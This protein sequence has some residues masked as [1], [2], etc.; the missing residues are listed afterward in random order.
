[1][2]GRKRPAVAL[3]TSA[4]SLTTDSSG[5]LAGPS[6]KRTVTRTVE[7]WIT[8]NDKAIN[9][10]TW[11]KYETADREHVA[12]LKCFVCSRFDDKLHSCR[13]YSASF[14]VGSTNLRTSSFKDHAASDMHRRAMSLLKKSQGAAVVEYAPIAKVLTTLDEDAE[15]K[16]KRK[17]EIAYF[18]CK[19]KLSFAK[20]GPLCALEKHGVDLGSGHK[21]DRACAVFVEFIALERRQLLCSAL[22]KAKFFSVQSDGSTDAGNIENELFMVLY[23]DSHAPDGIIHVR[24]K[25]LAVLQPTRADAKGLFECFT[26]ALLVLW[27]GRKR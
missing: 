19:Q 10:M 4:S 25:F 13:N 23:F 22:A 6:K 21:N 27:V 7:K 12:T 5:D 26:R 1:M 11:L 9:T 16:L 18:I 2:S 15:S 3:S 24:S 20:M 14:I 8:D 17:F